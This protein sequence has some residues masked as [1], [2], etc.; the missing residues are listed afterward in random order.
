MCLWLHPSKSILFLTHHLGI[1][2]CL[3]ALCRSI[4]TTS[5][6][7][8]SLNSLMELLVALPL[9]PLT[10]I[11]NKEPTKQSLL[12][13]GSFVSL[14]SS[15]SSCR[16]WFTFLRDHSLFISP[17]TQNTQVS[18]T[19]EFRRPF[20]REFVSKHELKTVSIPVSCYRGALITPKWKDVDPR[21]SFV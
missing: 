12:H 13:R 10:R 5:Y 8:E 17:S 2:L 21:K 4:M 18:E 1:R 16:R 3:M 6:A 15:M 19:K 14:I 20:R 7:L 9:I 11:T